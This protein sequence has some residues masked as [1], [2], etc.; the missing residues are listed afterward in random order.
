[1]RFLLALNIILLINAA[2]LSGQTKAELE[3][4][5]KKTLEEI[6]YVDGMLQTTEKQKIEG[7]NA[8]RMLG[9][10][11]YLRESVIRSMGEEINLLNDRIEINRI[12]LDMMEDDLTVL[13]NDYQR[14]IINSYKSK[15]INPEIVYLLSAKDFNQGYKRLKYLQQVTK[16]RRNESE[17]IAELKEQIEGT[18]E[19]LETD[20]TRISELQ[21]TEVQQKDLLKNE[22]TRRQRIVRSLGSKQKQ[23]QKELSEKKRIAKRIEE[24]IARVVEAERKRALKSEMTPEQ[25]LIGENFS[26]NKGRLPWPV[27]KGIITAHFGVYNHPVL[28]YVK[29][30]NV[31]I[32]ITSVGKI[33]ARS[34][35]KGE[36]SAISAITGANMTVIIRH[37]NYLTV[38]SNLVN[39]KVKT[40]D[41]VDVKQV[42]GE[43]YSD[44]RVDNSS[45]LK[46]MVFEQKNA[47]DPEIWIT[48]L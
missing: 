47:L 14:A 45:V 3:E 43:V 33:N 21:K 7:M 13:K 17:I 19:R 1:M 42:V 20:L 36:V 4:Q 22:Q 32:E 29:E 24:E 44:P 16:Y 46:F 8:L 48:K 27:E 10:K 38:Y 2:I 35:F 41:R 30:E 5:R 40:G 31:G 25:K 18:K 23:L 11:L 12:A 6:S 9:N 28:K 39:V 37:G 34:V 15:K 26:D